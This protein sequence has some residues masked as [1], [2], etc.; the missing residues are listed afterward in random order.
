VSSRGKNPT[1]E[2]LKDLSQFMAGKRDFQDHQ[3]YADNKPAMWQL[4]YRT[5]IRDKRRITGAIT[6][7]ERMIIERVQPKFASHRRSA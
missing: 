4:G 3:P 2:A 6:L 5:G 1:T 7:R